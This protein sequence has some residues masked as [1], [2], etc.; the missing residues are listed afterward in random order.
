MIY[1]R[2]L[3]INLRHIRAKQ[4]KRTQVRKENGESSRVEPEPISDAIYRSRLFRMRTGPFRPTRR[5]D[6]ITSEPGLLD[7]R[8]DRVEVG[9]RRS[10]RMRRAPKKLDM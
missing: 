2:T 5:R 4:E 10:T 1:E 9:L 7:T 6:I 3:Q 8:Q